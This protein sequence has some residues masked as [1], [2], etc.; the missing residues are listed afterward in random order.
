MLYKS[1]GFSFWK[2]IENF[3]CQTLF[4]LQDEVCSECKVLFYM[5]IRKEKPIDKVYYPS[6]IKGAR[7]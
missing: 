7:T 1:S 6:F 3:W 4:D 2:K 5:N